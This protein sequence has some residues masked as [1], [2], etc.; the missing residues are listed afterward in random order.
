[1]SKSEDIQLSSLRTTRNFNETIKTIQLKNQLSSQDR[2]ADSENIKTKQS[3][4][5]K[6]ERHRMSTET[7]LNNLNVLIENLS[8]SK[9]CNKGSENSASRSISKAQN[10][11]TESSNWDKSNTK[12]E[13]E[14]SLQ[15]PESDLKIPLNYIQSFRPRIVNSDNPQYQLHLQNS[16]MSR[17]NQNRQVINS[18]ETA[19]FS[20]S[21]HYTQT[22]TSANNNSLELQE[23]NKASTFKADRYPIQKNCS[24]LSC[25]NQFSVIEEENSETSKMSLHH[26]KL[27]NEVNEA[28]HGTKTEMNTKSMMEILDKNNED[29]KQS[30]EILEIESR[31]S[32]VNKSKN[33]INKIEDDIGRFSYVNCSDINLIPVKKN[34]EAN[35]EIGRAHV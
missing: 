30:L 16:P 13:K 9:N 5:R 20:A 6:A 2:V 17:L 23:I 27:S 4:C 10:P 18:I 25:Q 14:T 26:T 35:E 34:S 15:F 3:N 28:L 24:N 12:E 22:N 11:L 7:D 21:P 8:T 31:I 19:T 32:S 29:D 1:M 33:S